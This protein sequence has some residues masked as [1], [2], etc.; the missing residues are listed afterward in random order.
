MTTTQLKR[1]QG[2]APTA[3]AASPQAGGGTF[4]AGAQFWKVTAVGPWG[5]SA[6]SAE[7]TATLALN[8]QGSLTWTCP[9]GTTAVRIYRG[10]VTNTENALIAQLQG[11]PAAYSDTGTAGNAATPPAVTNWTAVT[12]TGTQPLKSNVPAGTPPGLFGAIYEAM[13][14]WCA[15]GTATT[16]GTSQ[17]A[18]IGDKVAA[19]AG[20]DLQEV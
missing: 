12:K 16:A 8:G 9:P 2:A 14:D 6:P 3:L 1:V 18:K 15:V 7:A 4:A 19:G 5:E 17:Q 20:Y 11:A 10:T 13:C